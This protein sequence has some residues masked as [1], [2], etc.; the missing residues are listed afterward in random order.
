MRSGSGPTCPDV[1]GTEGTGCLRP[2]GLLAAATDKLGYSRGLS[3]LSPGGRDGVTGKAISG[4]CQGAP[5]P[6]PRR[7]EVEGFAQLDPAVRADVCG[8]DGGACCS[9]GFCQDP[10]P[11]EGTICVEGSFPA[12]SYTKS[13]INQQQ[14]DR[15]KKA[16]ILAQT[17]AK[18]PGSLTDRREGKFTGLGTASFAAAGPAAVRDLCCHH[19]STHLELQ[20][21]NETRSVVRSGNGLLG[22]DAGGTRKHSR[23]IS[24]HTLLRKSF[25]TQSPWTQAPTLG[26]PRATSPF[27]YGFELC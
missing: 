8:C 20:Q 16:P 3:R 15:K 27:A 11:P 12:F 19:K 22:L 14:A 10:P 24:Q 7:A 6:S 26:A 17:K 4:G 5:E 21:T 23:Q 13:S 9:S 1:S 25:T 2:L 18:R